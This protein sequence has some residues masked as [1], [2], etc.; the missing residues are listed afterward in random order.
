MG[1]TIYTD[2]QHKVFIDFMARVM[3]DPVFAQVYE[4][5]SSGKD[6]L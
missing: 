6:A 5:A 1:Q 3:K 2:E 4:H